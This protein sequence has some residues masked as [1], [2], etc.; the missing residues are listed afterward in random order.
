[1]FATR[2]SVVLKVSVLTNLLVKSC[3]FIQLGTYVLVALQVLLLCK[4]ILKWILLD[5]CKN[6]LSYKN[7][8]LM[9]SV[10]VDL[11]EYFFSFQ[12]L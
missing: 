10:V 5:V 12:V 4:V 8:S 1:M 3:N 6:I 11:Y 9:A 2:Q 7:A